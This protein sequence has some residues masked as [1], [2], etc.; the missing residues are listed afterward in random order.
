MKV[1]SLFIENFGIFNNFHIENFDKNINLIYGENESGKTTLKNFINYIFFGENLNYRSNE[2]INF[3]G[4]LEI[5]SKEKYYKIIRYENSLS[6]IDENG[7]IV[8]KNPQ[9]LFLNSIDY[10]TYNKIFSLNINDLERLDISD[11]NINNVIFS[12]GTGLGNKSITEIIKNIE[13]KEEELISLRNQEKLINRKID[14][15]DE[16]DENIKKLNIKLQKYDDYNNK[17]N[18][19]IQKINSIDLNIKDFFNKKE[20]YSISNKIFP[21]FH[22]KNKLINEIS[23]LEYSS[24]FPTRGDERYLNIKNQ[25]YE[26]EKTIKELSLEIKNLKTEKETIKINEDILLNSE[27]IKYLFENNYDYKKKKIDYETA[28]DKYNNLSLELEEQLKII[29]KDWNINRLEDTQITSDSRNVAFKISKKHQ[30]ITQEIKTLEKQLEIEKINI[31]NLN[32]DKNKL[33]EERSNIKIDDLNVEN[34]KNKK[35]KLFEMQ[36]IF[37]QIENLVKR[38]DEIQN[39]IDHINQNIEKINSKKDNFGTFFG[40]TGYIIIWILLMISGGATFYFLNNIA[41]ISI[42]I[43]SFFMIIIGKMKYNNE[44][45]KLNDLKNEIEENNAL[46]DEK[47]SQIKNINNQIENFAQKKVQISEEIEIN[48]N[49]LEKEME[50]ELI[51]NE[52]AHENYQKYMN[53][54]NSIENT[55]ERINNS[56]NLVEKY[57]DEIQKL[58]NEQMEIENK[59]KEWL[60]EKKYDESYTPFNFE[61]FINSINHSKNILREFRNAENIIKKL[62]TFIDEY[63]NKLNLLKS[64]FEEKYELNSIQNIH[65]EL[66]ENIKNNTIKDS[67]DKTIKEKEAI[68]KNKLEFLSN[69]DNNILNLFKKANTTN[70]DEYFKVSEDFKKLTILKEN[71]NDLDK[72]MDNYLKNNKYFSEI[73]DILKNI[74]KTTIEKTIEDCDEYISKLK[75]KKISLKEEN[76]N[77]EKEKIALENLEEYIELIQK[78]ENIKNTIIKNIKKLLELNTSKNIIND[79]VTFFKNN[80]IAVFNTASK[81]IQ[82]MTDYKYKLIYNDEKLFLKDKKNIEKNKNKWSD[83]TLDQVYLSSRL[84]FIEEYNKKSSSLPVVL[85]DILIKFDL[86]R[87]RKALE[88]LIEFSK[89]NQIFVFTCNKKT[90]EIFESLNNNSKIYT[91]KNGILEK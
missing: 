72:Q 76:I 87:K 41:G 25:K 77:F 53:Y 4:Y 86:Y 37:T 66:L 62:K 20:I 91:L 90:K 55:N 71:I 57:N 31:N 84:A 35:I 18:K 32:L 30:D 74:D 28:K 15:I 9:E 45:F 23:S 16:L 65:E 42:S 33:I 49:I 83:G 69:L 58:K 14:K 7:K 6:I 40:T 47:Y 64:K 11:K 60:K 19:N 56:N 54:S 10:N 75:N 67:L 79:T 17:I 21:M 46:I 89:N 22:E 88:L 44:N 1:K 12:A 27:L 5:T 38:K 13:L 52:K 34:I 2:D 36:K 3:G 51:K 59:W 50:L 81:N 73:I 29:G 48:P 43:F 70:E 63:E 68:Y 24:C 78:R 61:G 26:T 85:D 8:N 82:L 80:R 39:E